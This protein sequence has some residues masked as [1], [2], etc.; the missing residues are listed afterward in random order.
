MPGGE[1]ITCRVRATFD[2]L[3]EPFEVARR[4]SIPAFSAGMTQ[5]PD[6]GAFQISGTFDI[7]SGYDLLVDKA[8]VLGDWSQQSL[9]F[10]PSESNSFEDF[11]AAGP[12][13]SES[14]SFWR[15]RLRKSEEPIQLPLPVPPQP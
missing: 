3:I 8:P 13:I 10:V 9:L 12:E 6:T 2:G 1:E 15:F 4:I 7:Q 14:Q 11:S 5:N